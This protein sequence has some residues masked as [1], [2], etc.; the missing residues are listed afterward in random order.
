MKLSTVLNP[1]LSFSL[2]FSLFLPKIK[3]PYQNHPFW[4]CQT[5]LHLVA[6]CTSVLFFPLH[7]ILAGQQ[8]LECICALVCVGEGSGPMDETVNDWFFPR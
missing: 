5:F 2:T 8:Q 6:N 1:V 3:T 7:P 4:S